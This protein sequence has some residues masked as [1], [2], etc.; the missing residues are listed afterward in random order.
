MKKEIDVFDY[1]NEIMNAVKTGVL[2][3][4]KGDDKVNSM[5]IS[6]GTLGIE[7][8]KQIFTVFVRENRFTKN[9]LDTNPEFTINIPYGDYDKKILG[10]CG[11]KSGHTIDKIKEL[12]LTLE[13]PKNVTV[14]GIKELPL[15]LECKVIYKQKQDEREVIEENKS[16]FY[17]Q[18]VDSSFHGANKD[19]HTAYYGEIVSAYIIE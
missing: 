17:P 15:T 18:D 2:L 1:A 4:T 3:T 9:Q 13:P 19:Y 6:W 10:I 7:W 14:P 16:I 5:T 8:S 12:N 11:T